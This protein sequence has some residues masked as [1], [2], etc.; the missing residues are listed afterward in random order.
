MN[1]NIDYIS[2]KLDQVGVCTFL[3]EDNEIVPLQKKCVAVF[4]KPEKADS[5]FVINGYGSSDCQELIDNII[6]KKHKIE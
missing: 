2:K 6:S 1:K 4:K 3:F 5:K